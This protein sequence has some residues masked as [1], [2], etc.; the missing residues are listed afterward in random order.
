MYIM[1]YTY[2]YNYKDIYTSHGSN[3]VIS[4]KD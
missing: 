1:L 3:G 4:F 2:L